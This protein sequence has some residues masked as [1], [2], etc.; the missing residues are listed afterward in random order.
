[1]AEQEIKNLAVYVCD[2]VFNHRN[3][4][5]IDEYFAADL[6]SHF[7]TLEPQH[8]RDVF[9]KL[10]EDLHKAMPDYRGE[11]LET[12]TEGDRGFLRARLTGTQEGTLMGLPGT[13]LS[14]E[15]NEMWFFRYA[16]GKIA[17]MWQQGDYVGFM[18]QIGVMP[19]L[20]AGA[21]RQATYPFAVMARFAA[22]KL[23]PKAKQRAAAGT[24]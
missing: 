22:L 23:K 17:E 19:P 11:I 21:F 6:I 8:G 7:P 15:F 4:K 9:M 1:M 3:H 5:V 10:A 2:Q 18:E 13:G 16:D 14:I 20:G 24:K 12:L